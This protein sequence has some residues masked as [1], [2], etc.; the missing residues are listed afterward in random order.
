MLT[1]TDILIIGARAGG[2]GES[3]AREAVRAGARV[4]GTTLNPSDPQEREFFDVIGAR[5]IDIPLR[6]DGDRRPD[7][8][9]AF[10]EIEAYLKSQGVEHLHAVIHAVAGGFPRQPAVMKAVGDILKGKYDF[11]DMATAVKRNVYYV[12]AGSFD[13]TVRGMRTVCDDLTQFIALTYRGDLPY[14]IADTKRHLEK[15]SERLAA[16]GKRTLCAAFP[17][18]WTQSSQFFTGIEIAVI[19]H[20]LEHLRDANSVREDLEPA[21]S[22]MKKSLDR[23]EGLEDVLAGMRSFITDQWR[24]VGPGSDRSEIHVMVQ[25]LFGRMRSDGT[26]PTLRR[27]VEAVSEFVREACGIRLV[28]D[29]IPDG[30]WRPGDIRQL[31]YPDLTGTTEIKE[32]PHAVKVRCAPTSPRNWITFEKDE[33]RSTLSMYGEGFLFVDRVVV[34]ARGLRDGGVGLGSF[35]VP[36]PDENPIM[37]DHFVGLPLFGGHLQMEAVAQF[38]TFM[39]LKALEGKNVVPILTGTV[40]P[41]LNTMAPPGEK[42]SMMGILHIPSK[43]ELELEAFIENRYGRSRGVIRGMILSDR[44]MKKMVSSF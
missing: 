23:I 11:S 15:L 39:I 17:E 20:Y 16:E 44:V 38:G 24:H 22:N 41:D 9:R 36:G 34:D 40:F 21:F 13:D 35:V 28:N 2:Y 7:A 12:N 29:L 4:F 33:I 31:R 5:L 6:F 30:N 26:F 32:A 37:R 8:F 25:D 10:D 1:G 14:F 42:L 3:I 19:H 18:A 43:R 27:A